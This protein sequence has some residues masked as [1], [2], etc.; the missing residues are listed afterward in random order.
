MYDV[1][2]LPEEQQQDVASFNTSEMKDFRKAQQAI[3]NASG[4]AQTENHPDQ[5]AVNWQHWL[6]QSIDPK[7]NANAS[8]SAMVAQRLNNKRNCANGLPIIIAVTVT[9]NVKIAIKKKDPSCQCAQLGP[10]Y[11]GY[12]R[13]KSLFIKSSSWMGMPSLPISGTVGFNVRAVSTE[14]R[15]TLAKR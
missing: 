3:M 7:K 4:D 8:C 9:A 6:D 2:T 10:F 1:E 13:G 12:K 5:P 15:I 14:P 11:I